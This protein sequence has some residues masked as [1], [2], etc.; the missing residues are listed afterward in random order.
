[1]DNINNENQ[2]K[3]AIVTLDSNTSECEMPYQIL[4][5]F[6]SKRGLS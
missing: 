5:E 4:N 3:G 2:F 6:L 1:M